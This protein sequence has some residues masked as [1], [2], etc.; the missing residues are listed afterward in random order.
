MNEDE[1]RNLL[2]RAASG[3]VDGDRV[4]PE[5]IVRSGKRGVARRQVGIAA[6]GGAAAVLALG[7]AVGIP[8]ALGGDGE[9]AASGSA[10]PQDLPTDPVEDDFLG[11]W[12]R[13]DGG[14]CPVP[15]EQ[16]DEQERTAAAYTGVLFE[17]LA[18]LDGEPMGSCL[19]SRPDYDGFYYEGDFDGYYMEESVAFHDADASAPD[20]AR[21]TGAAWETGGENW[22]SQMEDEECAGNEGLTCSWVDAEEGRVLL[23][24]GTR[25]DFVNPDTEAGGSAEY[26]MVGAFLFRDDVVVSLSFSLRFESDRSGPSLDQVVEIIKSI[27]VGQEAPEIELPAERDLADD[28]VGALENEI[29]GTVVDMGSVDLVRLHSDVAEYGGPVYGSEAT[30]MLFV[31][32]ELESGETVRF[33]VQAE[34]VEDAGE[35]PAEDVAASYAQCPDAECEIAADGPWDTSVHR[36]IEGERPSLTALEYRAGDGW[37]IGVGV[38]TVDGTEAPLVDFETLD[39]IVAGIR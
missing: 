3:P 22:E 5:A 10:V 7:A 34:Q 9:S 6:A 24:E 35:E 14:N 15:D 38:E 33:F 21:M 28:L 25:T 11:Q 20:W 18:E 37:M 23:M 17:G 30:H 4:D 19:E 13:A 26:P 27:P 1:V 8:A 39:A 2:G 32:A 31:L 12:V 36:T 16:T 29:P